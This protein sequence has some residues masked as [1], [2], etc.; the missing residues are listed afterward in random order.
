MKTIIAAINKQGENAVPSVLEALNSLYADAPSSFGLVSPTE[1]LKEKDMDAIT[2]RE[3]NSNSVV[4]YAHSKMHP[5]YTR[6]FLKTEKGSL[7]F[8]GRTYASTLKPSIMEQIANHLNKS[9]KVLE[10]II[11]EADGEYSFV[12]VKNDCFF[13][14]RDPVGVMPLYFGENKKFVAV[15]SNRKAL[16]KLGLEKVSSFPPGH[17]AFANK[18]GFE[19]NAVKTFAYSNPKS[20]TMPQAAETLQKLIEQSVQQRL[21]DVKEVAVAFS[22]GLD[23]SLIAFLASKCKVK[24]NLIHV[25]LE[26]QNETEEA[27][28]AADYLKLPLQVHLFKE[29]DVEAGLPKIVDII[30]EADPIKASIG[31]PFFWT[32]EKAAEAGFKVLLAG[33]GADELF[34]GYQRYVKQYCSEGVEEI[35]KTMFN[36]VVNIHESNLERDE[37]ICIFHNVELRL[38]FA[39]LDV[40]EFALDLPLELKFESNQDSPRKLVL[41]KVAKNVGLPSSISDKPKKAVQYSTGINSAIYRIAKKHGKTVKEYVNELFQNSK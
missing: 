38:P 36:D 39:S 1:I 9:E 8:E 27:I 22:G 34:G 40:V 33:Q 4:S 29:S 32:A 18:D 37:K 11:N 28:R 20:S 10:R 23:S 19:F 17:L 5:I 6:E 7:F 24:V 2:R 35:R 16:W 25:S 41:R 15:A 31:L 14:G 26:N 13:A 30:E 21:V 12:F 3:I